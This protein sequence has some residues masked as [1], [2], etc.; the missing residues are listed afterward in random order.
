MQ[1]YL[2]TARLNT[3]ILNRVISINPAATEIVVGVITALIGGPFL[4][5]Y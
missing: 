5:I 4:Y 1:E 3:E 2:Q